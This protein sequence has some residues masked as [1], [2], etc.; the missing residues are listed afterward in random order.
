M[1]KRK[2]VCR[3][4]ALS[5]LSAAMLLAF[6]G[7]TPTHAGPLDPGGFASLG[8]L[9]VSS[10][11][12]VFDTDALTGG[13][14]AGVSFAQGA[15]LPNIAV[16]TFDDIHVASGATIT[17]T[18]SRALALLSKGNVVLAAGST[19]DV[20]GNPGG[21]SRPFCDQTCGAGGAGR[22][23]GGAGG[24]AGFGVT[25]GTTPGQT[26]MGPG[27]G[28][29]G[30]PH[31]DLYGGGAGFGGSGYWI[32][33][34]GSVGGAPY[35]DLLNVLQGGS[36]GGGGGGGESAPLLVVPG[37]GGAG[38]GALEIGALGTLTLNGNV[39]ARGGNGGTAND[40]GALMLWGAGG[41][42]SGGGILL[43]GTSV[44]GSGQVVAAG[45]S[46]GTISDNMNPLV[47]D[48]WGGGG[49]IL[50]SPATFAVGSVP[51]LTA[52]V[53]GGGMSNPFLNGALDV[54][55][56]LTVVG[57]G[58]FVTLDGAGEGHMSMASGGWQL[59]TRAL[60]VETGGAAFAGA[61]V[62]SGHGIDFRGGTV[63]A[64][65][66]WSATGG[67]NLSG[68]GTLAGS[69][70]GAA[71]ANIAADGGTLTLGDANGVAGFS[72][73]GAASV[74]AGATL[75]LLSANRA[76]L[77]S[78]TLLGA[79]SRLASL[80]GI[81]LDPGRGL[82]ATGAAEVAGDFGNNG[83]VAGPSAGGQFLVFT[84]DVDGAGGYAGNILFSDGFSPGLSPTIAS[85]AGNLTLDA[86]S[87]TLM[88]LGGLVPGSEHD[89]IDVAGTLDL[90]GGALRVVLLGTY[91]PNAG[92]HYEL[93]NWAEL[94]GTFGSILL[95]GLS[96]QLAWDT[97][98]LYSSGEISVAV[99]PE[100]ETWALMAAGL[101][102]V[103]AMVRRRMPAHAAA[104]TEPEMSAAPVARKVRGEAQ[105]LS[106]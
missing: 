63:I 13:A 94:S 11:S 23:A 25:L 53:S 26:G 27:G 46:G 79:N 76:Q 43:H 93:F 84:G 80:N 67:A 5:S 68:F 99:I 60:R 2:S 57:G 58:Q 42:G 4:F 101:A 30:I 52:D 100:P 66:G 37:G 56:V 86:S 24:N 70:A 102:L 78:T 36:G 41:G 19:I 1:R 12:F 89:R 77:G 85:F 65:A 44:L 17:A 47:I 40:G 73:A 64:G 35:G 97:S 21:Y 39:Y 91:M 7:S 69:F 3:P 16:F 8:S 95:P 15:G 103:G 71:G 75:Q 72:H 49:R 81:T 32:G 22:A 34:P 20:S 98:R 55:P 45:S 31:T 14:F 61:A 74:A 62:T 105:P 10:G 51:G 83:L 28:A 38:G 92:S 48:G 18:G 54:A 59:H 9:V 33:N 29:G 88:E 96:T 87:T 104:A 50:L 90:R 106:W 82:T 6:L